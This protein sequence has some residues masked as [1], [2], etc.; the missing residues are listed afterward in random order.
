MHICEAVGRWCVCIYI[1]RVVLL[2]NKW[3]SSE[4][5]FF[6]DFNFFCS[7]K[8]ED[9]LFLIKALVYIKNSLI[10]FSMVTSR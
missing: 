2:L 9:K 5:L 10:F 8:F 1:N 3:R 6:V 4:G 7:L